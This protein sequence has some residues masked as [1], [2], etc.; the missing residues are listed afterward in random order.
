MA[1]GLCAMLVAAALAALAATGGTGALADQPGQRAGAAT[2]TY[3]ILRD[4]RDLGRQSM[5]FRENGGVTEVEV[6]THV[7]VTVGGMQVYEF[8]QNLREVW[9]DR[10]LVAF[11]AH[12]NDNGAR[13]T[14]ELAPAGS[15]SLL[16]ADGIRTEVPAEIV[17]STLWHPFMLKRPVLFDTLHGDLRDFKVRDEGEVLVRVAD[18]DV[19]ARLFVLTG[20]IKRKLW[21]AL[22]GDQLV[23]MAMTARDG[24]EVVFE[25]VR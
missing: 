17:S 6:V 2:L 1:R 9:R 22:R 25:V 11:N 16:V 14:V 10:R 19:P 18:R 12:T 21:Y 13:H 5:L 3:R 8:Q 7:Q 24:S 23:R 4:G 20:K 15:R